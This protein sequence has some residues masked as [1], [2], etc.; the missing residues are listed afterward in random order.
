MLLLIMVM[1]VVMKGS[2]MNSKLLKVCAAVMLIAGAGNVVGDPCLKGA[3]EVYMDVSARVIAQ[4]AIECGDEKKTLKLFDEKGE[5]ARKED[6]QFKF[7]VKNIATSSKI[8]VKSGKNTDYDEES[9]SWIIYNSKAV[10]GPQKKQDNNK[11]EFS[12]HLVG[13]DGKERTGF[14]G[15]SYTFKEG[16]IEGDWSIE[17]QPSPLQETTEDGD[18]LGSLVIQVSAA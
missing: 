5:K 7:K 15:K 13:A 17:A 16:D 12:L 2:A 8:E 14:D 1:I 6:R 10:D 9:G 18:Y 3:N 4:V 11:I